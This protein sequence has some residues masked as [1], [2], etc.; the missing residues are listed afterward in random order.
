MDFDGVNSDDEPFI[1]SVDN[2]QPYQF[3]PVVIAQNVGES[4]NETHNSD[5]DGDEDF[6]DDQDSLPEQEDVR[7]DNLAWYGTN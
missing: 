2:I 7:R 5:T 3:E 1:S 6:E 4:R